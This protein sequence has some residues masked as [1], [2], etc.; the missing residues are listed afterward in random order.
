MK[1]LFKISAVLLALLITGCGDPEPSDTA[2]EKVEGYQG[3]DD[4]R[5]LRNADAVGYDGAAIQKKLDAALDKNDQR[6]ADLDA[7]IEEQTGD[8]SPPEER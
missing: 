7:Q 8:A 2:P 3:R 5:S 6:P 1:P 4:T